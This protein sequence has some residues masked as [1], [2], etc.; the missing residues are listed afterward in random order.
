MAM[1]RDIHCTSETGTRTGDV[2][3]F[4]QDDFRRRI[5]RAV[6]VTASCREQATSEES[7]ETNDSCVHMSICMSFVQFYILNKEGGHKRIPSPR[8][9][10]QYF[11]SVGDGTDGKSQAFVTQHGTRFSGESLGE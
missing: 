10:I 8:F 2:L 11:P 5:I 1:G 9:T 6:L 4:V 7:Q 3:C